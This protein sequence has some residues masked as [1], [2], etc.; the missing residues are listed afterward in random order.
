MTDTDSEPTALDAAYAELETAR[1]HLRK[2]RQR[3]A[4]GHD[5]ASAVSTAE[6]RLHRAQQRVNGLTGDDAA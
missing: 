2:V 4:D 5:G 6:W 3:V 1:N